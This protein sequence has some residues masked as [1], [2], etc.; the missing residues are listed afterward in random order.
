MLPWVASSTLTTCS[1]W[2]KSS[3][4]TVGLQKK[5]HNWSIGVFLSVLLTSLC[6]VQKRRH[7]QTAASDRKKTK[8]TADAVA[9]S[10]FWHHN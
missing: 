3:T 10:D 9:R 7:K 1:L 4:A 2:F 8:I 6:F 5:I